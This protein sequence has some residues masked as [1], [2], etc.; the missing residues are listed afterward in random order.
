M[1][2]DQQPIPP[3]LRK[4]RTPLATAAWRVI[5]DLEREGYPAV[6]INLPSLIKALR[7]SGHP[8]EMYSEDEGQMEAPNG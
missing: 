1:T 7:S 3:K 8:R 5:F 6:E 4:R 2:A